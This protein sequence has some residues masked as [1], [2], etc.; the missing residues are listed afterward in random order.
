MF[1][2]YWNSRIPLILICLKFKFIETFW[3]ICLD[4]RTFSGKQSYA[5]K[6]RGSKSRKLSPS[7]LKT[8]GWSTISRAFPSDLEAIG[9][10]FG[11]LGLQIT[12]EWLAGK[13]SRSKAPH[14][15]TL[16]EEK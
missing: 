4:F 15:T 16:L 3:N 11:M 14:R 12:S 2:V 13:I 5:L 1:F 8:N 10:Q 9:S 7:E 6:E